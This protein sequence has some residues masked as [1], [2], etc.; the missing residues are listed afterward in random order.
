MQ[1]DRDRVESPPDPDEAKAR[2]PKK[3][4]S[5]IP[6]GNAGEYFV[7]GELLRRGFDAQLADRNTK[8]YDLLVGRPGDVHLKKVQVKSVR[9][10]PWYVNQ[11]SFVGDARAQMTIYV[12]IGSEK[13]SSPVRY[14]IAR[15]ADLAEHVHRPSGW[16]DN[17]FMGMKAIAPFEGKWSSLLI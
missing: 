17:A 16:Q 3:R 8:G 5:G 4:R 11:R 15:N 7:M 10:A 14:F 6:V 9:A 2:P 12:L 1:P 13:A